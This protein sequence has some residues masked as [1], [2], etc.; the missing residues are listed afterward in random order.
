MQI[1][2]EPKTIPIR[3]YPQ[4]RMTVLHLSVSLFPKEVFRLWLPEGAN[5]DEV[6]LYNQAKE[7]PQTWE[8]EEG[9]TTFRCRVF[10]DENAALTSWARVRD[11][12]L[13]LEY[14]LQNK[15]G[16]TCERAGIGTCY[17]M[18][19]AEDFRDPKGERTYAWAD[20][21]LANI[22]KDGIPPE[23]HEHHHPTLRHGMSMPDNDRGPSVIGVEARSGGA[24]AIAWETHSEY[25]GNSDPGVNCIHGGPEARQVAPGAI[26]SVR[27]WL[28][29][30][31]G[32]IAELCDRG[33][34][35]VS[36]H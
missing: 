22:A 25:S 28:G 18:A 27:G 9:G 31:E 23:C 34:K 6:A 20:G 26:A 4:Y 24:T 36:G 33:L 8:D 30:S 16:Q 5:A 15:S 10:D 1:T 7:G 2:I 29:W 13:E 19:V 17:Q 3:F 32:P 14:Q 11:D 21:R 35:A 12:H